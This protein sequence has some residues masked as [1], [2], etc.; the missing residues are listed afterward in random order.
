MLWYT[1]YPRD[2]RGHDQGRDPVDSHK[3]KSGILQLQ[4]TAAPVHA[5][6]VSS[7]EPMLKSPCSAA[8]KSLPTQGKA[9]RWQIISYIATD[10]PYK[11]DRARASFSAPLPQRRLFL[12]QNRRAGSSQERALQGTGER[13]FLMKAVVP[14]REGAQMV[15]QRGWG[16]WQIRASHTST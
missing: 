13:L 16:D 15:T 11:Q 8:P 5:L 2:P 6:P 3:K 12:F 7:Q 14:N 4:M 1:I 9:Q 10:N